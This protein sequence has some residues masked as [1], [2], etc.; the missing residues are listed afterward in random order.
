M[1]R[2]QSRPDPLSLHQ[3][4]GLSALNG[5]GIIGSSTGNEYFYIAG[6]VV[7]RYNHVQKKQ[8][9]FYIVNKPISSI[10]LS[11][12]GRYLAIGERGHQPLVVVWDILQEEQ[13]VSLSGHKH[14]IGCMKFSP[15][16]KY[17]ITAGFKHDKQLILWDWINGRKLSTQRL[18]NKV[19]SMAFHHSGSFFVTAGDRHL[20]WWN[21][22]EVLDGEAVGLEGQPA[23]ITEEYRHTVFT[24]V[25]CGSYNCDSKVYCT[26]A[27][28]IVLIFNTDR[29]VEKTIDLPSAPAYSLELFTADGA[30][31]LLV[32]ASSNG[33]IFTYSPLSLEPFTTLP[34]PAPLLTGGNQYPA[35][36]AVR[37]LPGSRADPIPKLA[38]IYSDHSL[39]I[40]DISDIYNVTIHTS[41][42]SHRSCIWDIQFV[43]TFSHL[44][45]P[46]NNQKPALP[47]A[48][49]FTCS[50]DNSLRC[51]NL[52]E[53]SVNKYSSQQSKYSEELLYSIDIT[54]GGN[55][56]DASHLRESKSVIASTAS[57]LSVTQ[58]HNTI[59]E[60]DFI[61]G[62]PDTEL[63]DHSQSI[64]SP[65][66][67]AIH[68]F[69]H[70][71]ACGDKTGHLRV[72][73]LHTMELVK[74]I[75]AHSAEIL[76]LH[77]SPP[78]VSFD[79]G[80]VYSLYADIEEAKNEEIIVLLATAGRDRLIHLFQA[81]SEYCPVDTLD[82]HSSSVI[83]VRFTSDGKKLISCGGD[84]TM[85]FC[86]VNGPTVTRIKTIQTPL[87]TINGLA[88]DPSNKFAVSS[89]QDKKLNIWNIQSG[90]LM[91]AYKSSDFQSELYKCDLD[92]SGIFLCLRQY[93][94]EVNYMS[95][96]ANI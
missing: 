22:T 86:S 40:W 56:S 14:G 78:L 54:D 91:R 45:V 87:G 76:T 50:A 62:M 34:T 84:K 37:K 89:G 85:V 12:D 81:Q 27:S 95:I 38:A 77:Y 23:C 75:Q 74:S 8:K 33:S 3:V 46:S 44:I 13:I 19:H 57:A 41:H 79:D 39:Y 58:Q 93:V 70:E 71:L 21:I 69:G 16:S 43:D 9:K 80:N 94:Y 31:G 4:L 65:R 29:M 7:I 20:K 28:G 6:S 66:S 67:L 49:F 63:P 96:Y 68:P 48:S 92:P 2:T 82:H 5:S 55:N 59:I 17:L 52:D 35:C 11:N 83:M 88:V 36:Y 25:V 42:L 90:K 53:E 24:D 15:D 51:W 26:A 1:R 10:A 61:S 30:P 72:Y 73:N 47:A 64:Y 60:F 18:S 32:V